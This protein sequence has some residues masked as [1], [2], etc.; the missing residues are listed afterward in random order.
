MAK[1]DKDWL[2]S[3]QKISK[4]NVFLGQPSYM[5]KC[6]SIVNRSAVCLFQQQSHTGS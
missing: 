3:L 4:V 2:C 1:N 5:Y 6:K